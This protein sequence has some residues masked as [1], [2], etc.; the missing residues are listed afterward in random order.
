MSLGEKNMKTGPDALNTDENESGSAKHE[1][2]TRHTRFV[3]L[4]QN[5]HKNAGFV[6]C[7]SNYLSPN[8]ESCS[9]WSSAV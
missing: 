8:D 3:H 9:Y 5:K 7:P 4:I 1:N 6:V 2:M